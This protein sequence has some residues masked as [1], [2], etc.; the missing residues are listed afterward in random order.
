MIDGFCFRSGILLP[1]CLSALPRTRSQ[2][3]PSKHL[4]TKSMNHLHGIRQY[5][6]DKHLFFS[7]SNAL[8]T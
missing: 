6:S 4:V 7:Q 2:R 8:F 3:V 1:K 5:I